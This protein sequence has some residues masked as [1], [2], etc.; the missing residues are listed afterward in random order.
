MLHIVKIFGML[1]QTFVIW[2]FLA[3]IAKSDYRAPGAVEEIT[4]MFISAFFM[5]LI[6]AMI[7]H[8]KGRG[9][10]KWWLYGEYIF[11]IALVHALL[12]KEPDSIKYGNGY[13]KCPYCAEMIK[14][15]AKVCR[16]CGR[17][18]ELPN[19]YVPHPSAFSVLNN[20][21]SA[22][23]DVSSTGLQLMVLEETELKSKPTFGS[24]GICSLHVNNILNVLSKEIVPDAT[25]N[26]QRIWFY[27]SN[28]DGQK[29]WVCESFVKTIV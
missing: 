18:I 10:Y 27:A 13:K 19:Y 22:S 4:I 23:N 14:L 8:K 3:I 17:D 12:L 24:I 7:A 11:I 28:I 26:T 16:Y 20:N 1:L 15:E 21:S 29:G 9:F 2:F 6:P 25:S 5:G